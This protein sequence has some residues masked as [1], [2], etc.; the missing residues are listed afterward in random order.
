MQWTKKLVGNED[1]RAVSPVIGVI[2][3]VAITVI[4]AAVIAAFVLDLGGG[5]ESEAQAGVDISQSQSGDGNITVSVTSMGNS[6]RI[7]IRG[8]A[9]DDLETNSTSGDYPLEQVGDS[10]TIGPNAG[11]NNESGTISIVAVTEAG[12]ETSISS[13]DFDFSDN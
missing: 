10:V 11:L 3:M 7:E 5:V 8:D 1:E 2:L 4:L 12:T 13:E 6:E 9:A